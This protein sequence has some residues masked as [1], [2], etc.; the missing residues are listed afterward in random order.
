MELLKEIAFLK[1]KKDRKIEEIVVGDLTTI[2]R[3]TE[4]FDWKGGRGTIITF[5]HGRRIIVR[6]GETLEVII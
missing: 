1:R 6:P 5:N 4:M 3:I 2:G